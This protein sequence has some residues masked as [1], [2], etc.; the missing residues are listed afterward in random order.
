MKAMHFFKRYPLILV[1]IILIV[2]VNIW[3][4]AKSAGKDKTPTA[5]V[6]ATSLAQQT[7]DAAVSDVAAVGQT[8]APTGDITVAA[9][10][11]TTTVP[12]SSFQTV[13]ASYFDDALFIGDSRT[14]GLA[15]YG[16]L[17]NA[18][19]FTSVGISIFQVTEKTA[20]N[21]NT[22]EE[23]T[24]A[25]KLSQK[26][27]GKIYIMLG[28]NELGTGTPES[29]A[30]AYSEVI[31]QVRQAQP[32]AVIYLQS[33]MLVSA[34]KDNPSDYINNNSIRARNEALKALENPQNNIFYLNVNEVVADANGC[35][36]ASYT[37]DGIHLLGNSLTIWED[38][39]KQHAIV[40]GNMAA[41]TTTAAITT[42]IPVVDN[43]SSAAY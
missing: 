21:P 29:W 36:E 26:H 14:E 13:D 22:G 42:T 23:C 19:Y 28:I 8:T 37:S 35:L 17:P 16:S 43:S 24:L 3:A 40:T 4:L 7:A 15:L 9:T 30:Q 27:Y 32:D 39:L 38:Y 11:A 41:S 5:S 10:T 6:T 20:G 1:F 25:T 31:A 2:A 18:D 33:I 34:A 12:V